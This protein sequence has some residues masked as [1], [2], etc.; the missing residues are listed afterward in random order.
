MIKY[1]YHLFNG[2]LVASCELHQD[3][4]A[5]KMNGTLKDVK[6]NVNDE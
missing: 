1:K 6:N 2:L 5:T 3:G 4:S